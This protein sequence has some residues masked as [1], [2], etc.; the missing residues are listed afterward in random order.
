MGTAVTA[1]F[2]VA[3]MQNMDAEEEEK[4]YHELQRQANHICSLIVGS[5]YAAI[6]VVIEIRKLREFVGQHFSGR[7]RLFERIYESRFKRLWEQFRADS[8]E[9]LPEW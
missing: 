2:G 7:M 9:S 1:G 6:D 3:A 8:G 4:R 5:D